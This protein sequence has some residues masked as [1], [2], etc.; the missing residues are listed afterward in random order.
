SKWTTTSTPQTSQ[1][2]RPGT[3]KKW[4]PTWKNGIKKSWWPNAIT[5]LIRGDGRSRTRRA[6]GVGTRSSGHTRRKW[7]RPLARSWRAG[8]TGFSID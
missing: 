3:G 4:T 2:T 8:V 1:T 5:R 6:S 7:R